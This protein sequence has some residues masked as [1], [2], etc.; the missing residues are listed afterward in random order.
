M[1]L[2]LCKEMPPFPEAKTKEESLEIHCLMVTWIVHVCA[3]WYQLMFLFLT[4]EWSVEIFVIDH[5]RSP[6]TT[7]GKPPL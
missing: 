5:I 6:F 3:P 7:I 4:S 2:A 1:F